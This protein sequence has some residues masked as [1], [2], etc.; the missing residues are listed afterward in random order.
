MIEFAACRATDED[1][2][3]IS[4]IARQ[5]E[6][7]LP[8]EEFRQ[9][10]RAFHW[11]LARASHNSLLAEVYGKVLAALFESEEWAAMLNDAAYAVAVKGIIEIAGSE[12]RHI[13]D[14]LERGDAV[15]ALEG[16]ER[17]LATVESRIIS[18][19]V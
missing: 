10:D 1:R 16:I 9:L 5:F 4:E 14:A 15:A 7:G 11:A 12:H 6:P 2:T 17:H 8:V 3:E 18:Q 13:A 19:L